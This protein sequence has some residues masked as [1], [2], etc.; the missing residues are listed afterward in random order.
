MFKDFLIAFSEF[1]LGTLEIIVISVVL[2]IFPILF[3]LASKNL[4]A[5][6]VFAWMMEK[7]EDWI[8]KK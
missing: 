3:I 6:G 7:P 4:D 5:K 2:V 8:G 1:G